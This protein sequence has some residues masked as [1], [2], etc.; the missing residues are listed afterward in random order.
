VNCVVPDWIGTE[1]TTAV[2]A[3]LSPAERAERHVPDRL[4]PPEEIAGAVARFARDDS[5]AGRVLVCWCEQ[6]WE[7]VEPGDL[8]YRWFEVMRE[9]FADAPSG[10][11]EAAR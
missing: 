10:A 4:T 3:A 7:L 5:L 6:P 8:G 2:A 1:A 11:R 9:S